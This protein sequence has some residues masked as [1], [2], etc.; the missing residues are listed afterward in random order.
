MKIFFFI[1]KREK[2]TKIQHSS[3]KLFKIHERPDLKVSTKKLE[4]QM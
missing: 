2:T 4:T 3:V 1:K